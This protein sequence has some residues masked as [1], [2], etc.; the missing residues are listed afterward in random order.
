M[1]AH[2]GG[3]L[4][5]TLG[6]EGSVAF[7]G[8]SEIRVPIRE[9]EVKDTTG[10]GDSYIG[11]FMVARFLRGMGLKDSMTFATAASAYTSMGFGARSSPTSAELKA[12]VS[13]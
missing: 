9:V 7:D 6:G 2:F 1:R 5:V 13:R 12:F 8:S 11:A 4:L 3:L 10:A